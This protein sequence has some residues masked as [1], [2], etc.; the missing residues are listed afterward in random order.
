MTAVR[1]VF[2][3]VIVLKTQKAFE[4]IFGSGF[5]PASFSTAAFASGNDT[6]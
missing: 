5:Q 2:T 1:C 4:R 3:V 6:R